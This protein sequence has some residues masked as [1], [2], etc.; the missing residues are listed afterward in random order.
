M[1]MPREY[2]VTIRPRTV[3]LVLAIS[4]LVGLLLL[5]IYFAWHVVTWI[6][7]AALLAAALNPAVEALE[8]RGLN[9]G[10]AATVV[11]WSHFSS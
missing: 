4:I 2:V 9:R 7:L 6:L 5:L 8:R 10:R 3:L 11:L 1:A